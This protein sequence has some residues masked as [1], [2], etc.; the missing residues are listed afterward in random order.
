MT[1]SGTAGSG[2]D[3]SMAGSGGSGPTGGTAGAGTSDAKDQASPTAD[4]KA[5]AAPDVPPDNGCPNPTLCAL[6]AALV[7]RYTFDGTG[8]KATDSVGTAHGTVIN[9]QLAGN[10]TV[11]LAGGTT[12]QYV[13]LPNGIVKS[14]T[15]ATFETWV[16][17]NG[18]AAWQRIFDFGNSDADAAEGTRGNASTT[19]Y[20]TP[21]A[22]MVA[23]FPGPS[24]M[25]VGFKRSDVISNNET[26]VMS[27]QALATGM[28]MHVALVV[29]DTNNQ[30]TLYK[31]GAFESSVAFTDSLSMLNDV[32]NW[33]GR[34]QYSADSGFAGTIHEFRIYRAALSQSAIMASYVAGANPAFLN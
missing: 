13:D 2:P 1:S 20:L 12:D 6:K 17:W 25:L 4:A 27:S 8:T 14:L 33:L 15:D 9:A 26:H 3:A 7:H 24:V 30:M 21:Q 34:S 18:G 10:G 19:L 23:S 11:V 16:T 22:M 28:M 5:D 32:N 29:D 31:N